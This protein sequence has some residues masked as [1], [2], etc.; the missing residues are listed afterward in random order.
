V[1]WTDI[2][3]RPYPETVKAVREVSYPM[4]ETRVNSLKSSK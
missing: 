3:D 2:C 4:Y 1:G